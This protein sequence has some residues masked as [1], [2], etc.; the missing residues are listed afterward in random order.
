MESE[1]P[2][3]SATADSVCAAGQACTLGPWR[4]VRYTADDYIVLVEHWPTDTPC[5][6]EADD[7][8][9]AGIPQGTT[10]NLQRTRCQVTSPFHQFFQLGGPSVILSDYIRLLQTCAK[11]NRTK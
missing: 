3:P 4:G 5:G 8:V 7:S 10:C 6:S 9:A 11:N 1:V 2:G